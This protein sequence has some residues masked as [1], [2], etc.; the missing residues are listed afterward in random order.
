MAR[1]SKSVS[2]R[3]VRLSKAD[4]EGNL[5]PMTPKSRGE[6]FAG[7]AYF[8]THTDSAP[9]AIRFLERLEIPEVRSRAVN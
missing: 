3:A 7:A 6:G 1:K 8:S 2:K 4:C 5:V 9:K